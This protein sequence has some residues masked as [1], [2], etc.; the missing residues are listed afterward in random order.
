MRCGIAALVK[1]GHIVQITDKPW[2]FKALLVAKPHQ[3][4][5]HNIEDFIWKFC[6]NYILLNGVTL[7]I[8]YPI[9]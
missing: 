2:L 8:A 1:V 9:P 7:M 3:E 4:T 6:V 5:V